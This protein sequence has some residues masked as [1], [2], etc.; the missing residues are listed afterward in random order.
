MTPTVSII[1]PTTHDRA[2]FNERITELMQQQTY[3]NIIEHLFDYSDNLVGT[4]RNNLCANAR[5]EIIIHADSDDMYS[6]LWVE[7]SVNHM[8][9][10][11]ADL[12]GLT[13]IY[14]ANDIRAWLYTCSSKLPSIPGATMCYKRS[15]WQRNP[16][17]DKNEG[18]D[19]S[20]CGNAGVMHPHGFIEDFCA[21]LHLSNT[22][23]KDFGAMEYKPLDRELLAKVL[24]K[25]SIFI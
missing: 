2:L 19:V 11:N 13:A 14:L 9:A 18:E 1:T 6:P 23:I 7:K 8:I 20:F 4:K 15:I 16:F 25:Q 24:E 22:T 10:Y 21:M 12:T 17:Q 3:P 5:G